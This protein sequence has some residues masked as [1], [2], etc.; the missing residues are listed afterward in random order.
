M[1]TRFKPEQVDLP[2]ERNPNDSV[3]NSPASTPAQTTAADEDPGIFDAESMDVKRRRRQEAAAREQEIEHALATQPGTIE[4]ILAGLGITD[5]KGGGR[6][7]FQRYVNF[8]PQMGLGADYGKNYDV[9]NGQVWDPLAVSETQTDPRQVKYRDEAGKTFYRGGYRAMN[10]SE[11]NAQQV[12]ANRNDKYGEGNYNPYRMDQLQKDL[13]NG[14]LTRDGQGRLYNDKNGQR[15]YFNDN[16]DKI[17]SVPISGVSA[18]PAVASTGDMNASGQNPYKPAA[19]TYTNPWL[20][21]SPTPQSPAVP[22]VPQT[23]QTV[24]PAQKTAWGMPAGPTNG[25]TMA[26]IAPASPRTTNDAQR[27]MKIQPNPRDLPPSGFNPN[28]GDFDVPI[29]G[30]FPKPRKSPIDT[31]MPHSL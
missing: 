28:P 5:T 16:Y 7:M 20:N 11:Y 18:A 12:A 2:D 24:Q 9:V 30:G 3:E 29:S 27:A 1:G 21:Q 10:S 6:S 14:H 31:G 17:G 8:Y 15:E 13:H 23:P 25:L 22:S 26:P 4:K 19:S